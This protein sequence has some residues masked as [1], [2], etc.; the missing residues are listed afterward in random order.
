[1]LEKRDIDT[2]KE[3]SLL[4]KTSPNLVRLMNERIESMGPSQEQQERMEQNMRD[5]VRKHKEKLAKQ[6]NLNNSDWLKW[7]QPIITPIRDLRSL[8]TLDGFS[9]DNLRIA[10]PLL[11]IIGIIVGGTY[12]VYYQYQNSKNIIGSGIAKNTNPIP[13]VTQSPSDLTRAGGNNVAGKNLGQIEII[14]LDFSDKESNFLREK[15]IKELKNSSLQITEIPEKADAM[16]TFSYNNKGEVLIELKNVDN[17]ILWS[18]S[19]LP[20]E[21]ASDFFLLQD[22]FLRIQKEKS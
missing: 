3:V 11:V 4:R 19:F 17:K 18:K 13:L 7:L 21:T 20:N 5:L 8:F 9:I 12:L 1:M 14:I 2:E 16:L 10:V 15:I 6:E 22:L